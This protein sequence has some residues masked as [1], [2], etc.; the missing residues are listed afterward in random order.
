MYYKLLDRTD[1]KVKPL[2]E[3][4]TCSG[5]TLLHYGCQCRKEETEKKIVSLEELIDKLG[6]PEVKVVK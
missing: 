1:T 6:M 4:C 3:K 2:N 5:Y